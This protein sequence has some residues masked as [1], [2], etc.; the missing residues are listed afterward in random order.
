MWK[1]LTKPAAGIFVLACLTAGACS[2]DSNIATGGTG[3]GGSGAT[4]GS[5]LTGAGGGI[6]GTGIGGGAGGGGGEGQCLATGDACQS[7]DECCSA[8]CETGLCLGPTGLCFGI[9]DTCLA[10]SENSRRL[11]APQTAVW[12][13]HAQLSGPRGLFGI[14]EPAA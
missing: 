11:K 14:G 9:G 3:P 5:G 1:H 7:P 4:G 8:R 6:G 10:S 13:R 2:D 12:T